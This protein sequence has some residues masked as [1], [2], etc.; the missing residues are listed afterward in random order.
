MSDH[1]SSTAPTGLPAGP[2]LS[3]PRKQSRRSRAEDRVMSKESETHAPAGAGLRQPRMAGVPLPAWQQG[4]R[5]QARLPRRHHR[6]GPDQVLVAAPASRQPRDRHRPARPRRP[7]RRP[8]RRR[9]QRLRRPPP[10]QKRRAC[11]TTVSTVIATPSGGL[12]AYFTGSDQPSGRLPRQH[13][14]FRARGGYVLAPPS[15]IDG[16]PYRVIRTPGPVRGPGL[17]RRDQPPQPRAATARPAS[18]GCGTRRLKPPGRLG[19]APPG[20]Q[21]QRRACTGPP[22][23]PS[24]PAS[25]PSWTT[26]PGQQQPPASPTA[27]SP[28]P[29]APP[30]AAASALLSTRPSARRAQ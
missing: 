3:R 29:S 23:A 9:G 14:D 21:P 22:A 13:L 18:Q 7:G 15:Q 12:H 8:A 28:G 6:P 27:R 25:P 1:A 19:R 17:G 4:T 10:A 5:D 24:K 16:R 20:R 26:W 30:G 2:L 11:W